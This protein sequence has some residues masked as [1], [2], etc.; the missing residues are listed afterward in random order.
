MACLRLP[1][2]ANKSFHPSASVTSNKYCTENPD[3]ESWDWSKW[4][5]NLGMQ[6]NSPHKILPTNPSLRG[7][8]IWPS[9]STQ[10]NNFICLEREGHLLWW[11]SGRKSLYCA[12]ARPLL[13]QVR[14]C[15]LACMRRC[16]LRCLPAI[17]IA[18][19]Q[20]PHGPLVAHRLG[21]TWLRQLRKI[22]LDSENN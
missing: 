6:Q 17:S 2:G 1:Q 16:V 15:V 3:T 4:K 14:I 10:S 12:H 13:M 18:Q 9:F 5:I 20:T 21:G 11:T 8:W 7:L 19:L 22:F